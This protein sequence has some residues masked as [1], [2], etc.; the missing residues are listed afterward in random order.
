MF[1]LSYNFY[2]YVGVKIEY[3][4]GNIDFASLLKNWKKCLQP[5]QG[6]AKAF[7]ALVIDV[8]SKNIM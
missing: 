5:I 8:L 2:S 4:R 6:L 3:T 1:D 7:F